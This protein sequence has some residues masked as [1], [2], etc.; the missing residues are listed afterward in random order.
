MI[1]TSV[2]TY[3]I[4]ISNWCW[5]L[6]SWPQSSF[7]PSVICS[8]LYYT[9]EVKNTKQNKTETRYR[10]V[11][12]PGEGPEGAPPYF[13]PKWGQKGRK[14]NLETPKPP[15]TPP[16]YLRVWMIGPPPFLKVWIRHC[17]ESRK[18]TCNISVII[19]YSSTVHS[20]IDFRKPNS[21]TRRLKTYITSNNNPCTVEKKL[22]NPQNQCKW[23]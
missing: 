10:A 9:R 12:D 23:Y 17:R 14:K 16:T 3:F 18:T 7:L 8:W 19:Y 5:E 22:T 2:V 4:Y 6:L 13:R 1:I 20:H 15:P 11:T 21:G